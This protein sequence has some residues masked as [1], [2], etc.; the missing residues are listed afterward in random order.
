MFLLLHS[1]FCS[2]DA[3]TLLYRED[4]FFLCS[5]SQCVCILGID[6]LVSKRKLFMP[7]VLLRCRL[8]CGTHGCLRGDAL[9]AVTLVAWSG[10]S[11]VVVAGC[12]CF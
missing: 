2:F 11:L 9:F 5:R 8:T 6:F 3:G 7:R 12:I 4:F 10:F 1:F